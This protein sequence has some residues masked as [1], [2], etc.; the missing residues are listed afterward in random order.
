[1]SEN[2]HLSLVIQS[3]HGFVKD[4][5]AVNRLALSH[6]LTTLS[7]VLAAFLELRLAPELQRLKTLLPRKQLLA[8][9]LETNK[10]SLLIITRV[11]V[12]DLVELRL[13]LETRGVHLL[14]EVGE[15]L[16]LQY[17]VAALVRI[18]GQLQRLTRLDLLLAEVAVD[19]Q[20]VVV[21]VFLWERHEVVQRRL[22][23]NWHRWLWLLSQ[24]ETK[25]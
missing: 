23:V 4:L 22:Q 9:S 2:A 3:E 8:V 1:M 20:V 14:N 5:A 7:S 15:L 17:V 18:V 19:V 12:H 10:T 13:Q 21:L 6:S 25:V 24:L 11:V 16:R